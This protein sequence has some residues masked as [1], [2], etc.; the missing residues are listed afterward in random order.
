MEHIEILDE[1]NIFSIIL[2]A[3]FHKKLK[4]IYINIHIYLTNL[5]V[6]QSNIES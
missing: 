3:E 6:V 4:H 1:P 5:K 2:L